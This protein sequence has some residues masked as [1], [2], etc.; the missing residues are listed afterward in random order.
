[1]REIANRIPDI[2][3]GAM[4]CKGHHQPILGIFH[5]IFLAMSPMLLPCRIVLLFLIARRIVYSP[6]AFP[7]AVKGNSLRS[8]L[9][10]ISVDARLVAILYGRLFMPNC[11]RLAG[12]D[13]GVRLLDVFPAIRRLLLVLIIGGPV[14]HTV[15]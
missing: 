12:A 5:L 15:A 11:R 14:T 2:T 3:G 7:A 1:M 6:S 10:G 9:I 13:D 8:A 4:V